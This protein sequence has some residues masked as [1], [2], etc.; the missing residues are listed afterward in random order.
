MKKLKLTFMVSLL[1]FICIIFFSCKRKIIVVLPHVSVESVT[2]AGLDSVMVKGK[3]TSNGGGE[4]TVFGLLYDTN[5]NLNSAPQIPVNNSQTSFSV[6]VSATH[7]KTYYFKAF[8]TNSSGTGYS[9]VIQYMVPA[10]PP[11]T[12]PCTLA[13]NVV[14]DNGTTFSATVMGSSSSSWGNYQISLYGPNE[15]VYIYFPGPPHNGIYSTVADP[16]SIYEGQVCVSMPTG[17]NPYT[18]SDGQKVYLA[19]DTTS[20]TTTVTFCNLRYNMGGF[21]TATI[22]G[23][24]T[25]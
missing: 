15:D 24:G 12:A 18:V 19:L 25:Y 10:P 23:K 20:K 3:I 21:G 8:A 1:G 17:F 7:Y 6:I 5:P 14:V 16:S 13:P 9:N 22:S 4:I 2:Y 11:A